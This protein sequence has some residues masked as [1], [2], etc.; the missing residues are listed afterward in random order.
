MLK[1]RAVRLAAASALALAGAFGVSIVT[2]PAASAHGC[3]TTNHYD[4]Y[5]SHDHYHWNVYGGDHADGWHHWTD[6]A[7][8]ISYDSGPCH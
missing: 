3:G 8:G 7:L 5:S 4:Y 6:T 2:A 1:S